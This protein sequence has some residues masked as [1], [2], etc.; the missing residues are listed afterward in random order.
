MP[1]KR[2]R[3]QWVRQSYQP[4]VNA[5]LMN[6]DALSGYRTAAGITINLPEITIWRV[7]LRIS[8][9]VTIAAA[10]AANDGVMV[11][12]FTE[13]QSVTPLNQVSNPL[14]QRDMLSSMLYLSEPCMT[15]AA[16]GAAG[17]FY[18]YKEY[19]I[20]AH[21]RLQSAQDT[22]FVQL[23]SSGQVQI[24]DVSFSQSILLKVA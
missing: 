14:D 24:A 21:R 8:I 10:L 12:V 7:R 5:T 23:A 3:W 20:K 4:T 15:G 18:L 19:D 11:S 22:L 13:G 17:T 16:T 1:R 9:K 2:N 6:V